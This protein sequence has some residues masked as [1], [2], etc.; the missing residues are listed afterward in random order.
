MGLQI[1]LAAIV[2]NWTALTGKAPGARPSAVVK[3]D[4]YGLGAGRV[5]PA[6]HA[7]G[8]RDFFV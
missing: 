1:D 5:V 3:A 8:C 4:A 7:A 6:L 2:A